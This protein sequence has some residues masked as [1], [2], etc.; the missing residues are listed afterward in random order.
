MMEFLQLQLGRELVFIPD[1]NAASGAYSLASMIAYD[2]D[3]LIIFDD[4]SPSYMNFDG[5][6]YYSKTLAESSD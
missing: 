2:N 4:V 5:R 3:P 6:P 1:Y